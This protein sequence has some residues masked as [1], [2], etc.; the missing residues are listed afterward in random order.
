MLKNKKSL[1]KLKE[2]RDLSDLARLLGYKPSSVSFILY[3]LP[4]TSKYTLFKIPKKD[5]GER[6]I[7][8]PVSHL[9]VL[10]SRLADLLQQCFEEIYGT[11]TYGRALS[12]GF[13][14]NHSIITNARRHKNKRYVFNVDLI[15]YFPSIN[16]GRVRGYF[17]KNSNFELTPSVATVVAQI[18]C[19]DNGLPQGSPLSPIISNLIGHVLDTKLVKLAK[20]A[21]C[22]YS[23]Y[24]D[25]LTFSTRNKT[26]PNLIA[27]QKST[28]EWL[29]SDELK[30][31]ITRAGFDI[32]PRKVS[33]QYQTNR[34]MTTGLVVNRKVN[35]RAS[36]YRQAR[37]MCNALFR[38]GQFY[39]GK[40]MWCGNPKGT[41]TST[42]GN[43]NQLRGILSHI[44]NI[45]KYHDERD[46]QEQWKKPTAIQNL[47]RRFLYFDKFHILTKPLV[48][49]E[50]KTDNVH[51][52]CALKSL[53]KEFPSM[54]D[55][56]GSSVDWKV[57]FFNHSERNRNFMR[58]SGGTG[59]FQA[60]INRY[61]KQMEPFICRGQA[62]PVILLVDNDS[63]SKTVMKAAAKVSGRKVV[64]RTKDFYHL[65]KNLY[66]VVLPLPTGKSEVEIEDYYEKSVR[67]TTIG[68]KSFNPDSQSFNPEIHYGKHI[69]AEKVVKADQT[70]INFS[71]FKPLLNRLD[72]AIVDYTNKLAA[73]QAMAVN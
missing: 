19:H 57:D 65:V 64:D 17:I 32:N 44:Y 9:K 21:K 18:A 27:E 50:G 22:T 26:F 54:I 11:E 61:E 28:G 4:S 51:L 67:S 2:T 37:S 24:A 15:D 52:K 45:K 66:L 16:F 31:T 5:G 73:S 46:M 40:E 38:T 41:S 35:I 70:N 8:A 6:I 71:H 3:K 29:P 33:M 48:F 60:L 7:K 62:F 30:A 34:Q 69:F 43:I 42:T 49:C 55:I 58:F 10:Q 72:V 59:D 1:T 56:S 36:Y 25:D 53:A 39:I 20:K 47:F 13:R 12:H 14:K 68:N 63:G 23:R